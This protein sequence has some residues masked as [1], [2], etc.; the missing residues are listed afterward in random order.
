MWDPN[1]QHGNVVRIV[2]SADTP[3]CVKSLRKS[4]NFCHFMKYMLCY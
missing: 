1:I 4:E 2:I 3:E